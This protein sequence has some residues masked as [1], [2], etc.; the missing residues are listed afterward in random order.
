MEAASRLLC[1]V[2]LLLLWLQLGLRQ[3]RVVQA[4]PPGFIE[5]SCPS[6]IF[7]VKLDKRFLQGKFFSLEL[8]DP[9]GGTVLLDEKLAARC[10]YVLSE[11]VWGNT[12]FRAS[13]LG[14]H[15]AN[16][17]DELFSLTINIKVSSS[18]DMRRAATYTYPMY[19]TYT[20]WAPREIVCEEN[21]M[22]VSVKSDV[23][24]I[25]DDDTATWMSA[26]PEVQKVEYQVWQLIFLSPSGRKKIMVSDAAKLG[27]SFNNTLARVFLRAPYSTNE[28]KLAVVN[29]VS[30]NI[31]SSTSMYKQ[32][33]MLLLIDTTVACPIDGTSFT[34]T[35]ITWTVP[36][37]IP[38]LVPQEPTFASKN[39]SVGVDGQ[40]IMHPEQNYI[41][42]HN[43]THIRMT[44]PIGAA[45][46]RLKSTVA[47]GVHG[48][49]YSISLFLE[50]T[51]T[52]VDWHM[53][54]YTVIK[55]ITTP[56][57]PRIPTVINN[58]LPEK[59]IFDVAF[60]SFLPDVSLVTI[61]I[62]N[63]PL[64]PRDAE[65]HGYKVY[66]ITFP[67]GTKGFNLEVPF[68]D[69]TVLKEYVNRNETKYTLHVNYTLDVGPE[70]KPY[71]H[72]AEVE[73]V[74]ADIELPEAVGYCD[75]ENLYLAVPV[76]ALYQYWNLYI[77]NKL[78]NQQTVLSNR[79]LLTTNSTH[80]VLQVPLFTM[81]IIYEEVSF[82]RLKTRF[83][84]ALR[85][86]N[87]L[88]TI[89]TFS[90]SCNFNS[91]EFIVCY[92]NGTVTVSAPMKTIPSID[93]GKTKLKDSTCKP[94]EFNEEQAF[95]QFHVST[96]GTSLKFE[97]DHIIYENEISYEKEILPA[98]GP[99]KITRDPDYRL[100][101]LCY[102]PTK[103][104]L[105]HTAMV[106]N[107]PTNGSP[108]FG[109]GTMMVRSSVAE[110]RRTRQVLNIIARV[111][112][113]ESF[114]ELYEPNLTIVQ[115][116]LEPMFFEVELK[117]EEPDVELHLNNCWMTWSA[118]FE[119]TSQW[120]ITVDGCGNENN[121]CVT[122]FYPVSVSRRVKHPTHF[123]RLAVR[124]LIPLL[125][126]VHLHCTVTICSPPK[127]SSGNIG[128][129]GG[130]CDPT[131][132]R[133]DQHSEP[134]SGLHGYVLAGPVWIVHPEPTEEKN[135]QD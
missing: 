29:G 119:S 113:D 42:E 34:D 96:C 23:P 63:V 51:W 134:Y 112:K 64:S 53:T 43:K 94:K 62:G 91:S 82:Q 77:G 32:R 70:M 38:T 129:C 11:D 135:I 14:C 86:A 108:R 30:M 49:I 97:G 22:E 69:P 41:L 123:K 79:H 100:T 89:K 110:H 60:G 27:Y 24:V 39:I 55:P 57:M 111:S 19:C 65:H 18:P 28:S 12:I 127:V 50:H 40:R 125:G 20:P 54:K 81:G 124:M 116:S 52:D 85:K 44:I 10:G 73:C 117:D 26:L 87:T 78:L 16:Q 95:F 121:K 45:G 1:R 120:N 35:A 67:N 122:E 31:V 33:W 17:A 114:M 25:S 105:I 109:Y 7:W 46:G 99:P 36:S 90:V 133:M 47:N 107:L 2:S 13:V 56:F 71:N 58:T 80:L 68:D 5:S 48:I 98:W 4:A 9:S 115:S 59:R 83:D 72:P 6:R 103:E 126:Q 61:T 37:I 132:K 106:R 66:E 102:Y 3:T 21:Y 101:V 130:W 118:D 92:P 15:V 84:L 131:R 76:S 75:K 104:R 128:T 74:V 8:V 88:E 93:M